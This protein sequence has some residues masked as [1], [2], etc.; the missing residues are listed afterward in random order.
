MTTITPAPAQSNRTAVAIFILLALV[1]LGCLGFYV[2]QAGD[3]DPAPPV[4]TVSVD[5]ASTNQTIAELTWDSISAADRENLCLAYNTSP[6]F[7]R[8]MFVQA[9]DETNGVTAAEAWAMFEPIF[10]REC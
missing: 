4:T 10:I 6:E 3:N 5:D 9:W 7:E 8:K 1:G 2:A